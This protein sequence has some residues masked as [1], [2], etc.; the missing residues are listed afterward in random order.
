MRAAW[1]Y[2]IAVVLLIGL[3]SIPCVIAGRDS[4]ASE[5]TMVGLELSEMDDQLA[6]GLKARRPVEFDFINRIT[7]LARSGE[8]PLEMVASTFAWA[9]RKQPYPFPYFM[10]ALRIRAADIGV[11]I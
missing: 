6:F 9:R 3:V 4:I 1:V 11:K 2:L 8:L 7:V 10:R 5:P